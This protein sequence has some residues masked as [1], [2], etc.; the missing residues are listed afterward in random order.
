MKGV[1]T[2]GVSVSWQ[3]MVATLAL[4]LTIAAAGW[5]LFQSQFSAQ[6]RIIQD[7]KA[8][9]ERMLANL[10]RDME[11]DDAALKAEL[12]YLRNVIVTQRAE[13][14]TQPEFTQVAQSLRDRLERI[15]RQLQLLE[16]TRPTTAEL[17][18]TAKALDSQVN[19]VE[20]RLRAMEE[21]IRG[22]SREQTL[23]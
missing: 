14:V 18:S 16:S 20:E 10:R 23:K 1:Q 12:L 6:D 15:D 3:A 2:N 21:F 11:N 13:L 7:S 9:S 22:R 17:Q 19:R 5:T 8:A 4:A